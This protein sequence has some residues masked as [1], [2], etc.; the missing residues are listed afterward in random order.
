MGLAYEKL[1]DYDN[2]N[3]IFEQLID[4]GTETL[5][6]TDDIDFFSKFG[7]GIEMNRK[8]ASAY[9]IQGLGYLGKKNLGKASGFFGKTLDLDPNHLWVKE[10]IS[11]Q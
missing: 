5:S 2:A 3:H 6:Q 8:Q 1:N 11:N 10:F 4:I 7:E 9:F